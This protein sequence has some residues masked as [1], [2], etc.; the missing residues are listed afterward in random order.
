MPDDIKDKNSLKMNDRSCGEII[1][2]R[3]TLTPSH[4][5]PDRLCFFMWAIGLKKIMLVKVKL[6]HGC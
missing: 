5:L 6:L 4:N 1:H 2:F 3:V